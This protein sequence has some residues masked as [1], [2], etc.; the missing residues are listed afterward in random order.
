MRANYWSSTKFADWLRG[1]PKIQSGTAKEW[2]AWEK[3]AKAMKVRYWLAEEGLD[4][5]QDFVNWPLDRLRDIRHY[6]DNRWISKTHAL[7]STLK[8]GQWYELD[9]RLLHSVFDEL[10][11]FVEIEQASIFG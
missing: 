7:T 11:D 5:L 10:V 3:G 4:Y 1:T 8:R 2:N 9:T 6:I